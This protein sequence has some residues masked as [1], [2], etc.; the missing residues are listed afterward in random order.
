MP[1]L[2]KETHK[3]KSPNRLTFRNDIELDRV[4]SSSALSRPLNA[5]FAHDPKHRCALEPDDRL[6]FGPATYGFV[7]A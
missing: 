4:A 2:P 5:A 1:T 3:P 7:R 6:N